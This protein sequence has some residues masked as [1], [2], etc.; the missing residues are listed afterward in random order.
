MKHTSGNR[1]LI[2]VVIAVCLFLLIIISVFIGRYPLRI[3]EIFASFNSGRGMS[4]GT[5]LLIYYRLPRIILACLTGT[6][7][8]V[9]GATFQGIFRNPMASPDILGASSGAAFGAS[10]GILLGLGSVMTVFFSFVAGLLT[11]LFVMLIGNGKSGEK[12]LNLILTGILT[13]SLVSAG[14]SFVK[15]VA[16]PEEKLPEITYFLMGSLGGAEYSDVLLMLAALVTG[17]IPL[18]IMR[19]RLNIL[20]FSDEE[21][22]TSGVNTNRLRIVSIVCATILTASSVAVCGT[23]SWIGLVIPHFARKFVGSSFVHLFSASALLGAFFLL[24]TDDLSR[25]LF[26]TEIPIGI[27]TAIIG[28]PLFIYLILKGERKNE[29]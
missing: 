14:T 15:L 10:V 21:A 22:L 13:G 18:Y 2:K 4:T 8:A 20:S 27:L 6:A 19:W 28:A 24:L 11:V 9:S 17:F 12:T 5:T 25:S 23:I 3:S 16:D 1:K 26:E 7:L 29:S